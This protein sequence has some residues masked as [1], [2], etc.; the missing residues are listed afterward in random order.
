MGNFLKLTFK[1]HFFADVRNYCE[2]R[3]I[4]LLINVNIKIIKKLR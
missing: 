4:P 2:E 3:K 1:L